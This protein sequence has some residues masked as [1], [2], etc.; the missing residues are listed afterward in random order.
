MCG[1]AVSG[2]LEGRRLGKGE[3]LLQSV[4]TTLNNGISSMRAGYLEA[5]EETTDTQGPDGQDK[6]PGD[7]V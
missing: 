4:G 7:P 1:E 2:W 3:D 5:R 6:C